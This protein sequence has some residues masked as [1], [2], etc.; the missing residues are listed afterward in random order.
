MRRGSG[1]GD[2]EGP[3]HAGNAVG[4]ADERVD[5][6]HDLSTLLSQKES[7]RLCDLEAKRISPIRQL[8][9]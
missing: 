3:R 7:H 1:R 6:R 4:Y 2:V 9:F 8:N 5:V